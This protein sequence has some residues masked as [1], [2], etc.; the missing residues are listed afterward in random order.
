MTKNILAR[1]F[2][3]KK[4]YF[5]QVFINIM[6]HYVIFLEDSGIVLY[7]ITFYFNGCLIARSFNTNYVGRD[8]TYVATFNRGGA[9]F[10]SLDFLS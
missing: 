6:T 1:N 8:F 4:F 3:R 5:M 9:G 7:L 2:M 10:E